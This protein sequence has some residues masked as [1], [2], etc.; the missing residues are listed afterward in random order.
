MGKDDKSHRKQDI[1][2]L[3]KSITSLI[4]KNEDLENNIGRDDNVFLCVMHSMATTLYLL[5]INKQ[6]TIAAK[7]METTYFLYSFMVDD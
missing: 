3:E 5:K 7:D 1:P 6:E 4:K 2:K